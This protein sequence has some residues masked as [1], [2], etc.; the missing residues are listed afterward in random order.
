MNANKIRYLLK[1]FL[2]MYIVF[3]NT[4]RCNANARLPTVPRLT[5]AVTDTSPSTDGGLSLA[6][7]VRLTR[8]TWAGDTHYT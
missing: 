6:P 4:L 7:G 8:V 1:I 3:T 5:R 2:S